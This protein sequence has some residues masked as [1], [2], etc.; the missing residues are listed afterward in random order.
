MNMADVE[1]LFGVEGGGE[2]SGRSGSRIQEDLNSIV[3]AINKNPFK[4]KFQMDPA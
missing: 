3:K 1:L 4:I 2:L